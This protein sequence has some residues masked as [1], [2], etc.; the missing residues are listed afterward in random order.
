MAS[1]TERRNLSGLEHLEAKALHAAPSMNG[2]ENQ[3]TNVTRVIF[4]L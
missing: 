4:E 2:M 3:S 1:K